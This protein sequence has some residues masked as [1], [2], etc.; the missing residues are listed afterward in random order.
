MATPILFYGVRGEYGEFSNWF[1]AEF[2]LDGK[3]WKTSEHYFM[4]QK[5]TDRASQDRIRRAK[6]P[7]EAKAL[8]REVKLR[9]DWDNVKF[10]AMVRACY[11]KFSQ[12]P[13]LGAILLATGD[14]PI[15]ED[16]DD[17]WWGGGPNHPEGKDL[18][19]RALVTV[20]SRLRTERS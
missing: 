12:N 15:H 11:A 20:R 14:A 4:A 3:K 5:T 8:G 7:A 18:L 13:A 16:C 6:S 2:E 17:P 1:A 10:D 19:G 9:R